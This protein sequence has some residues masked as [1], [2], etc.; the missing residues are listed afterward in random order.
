VDRK[1]A[2]IPQ[3]NRWFIEGSVVHE[4]LEKGFKQAK[5]MSMEYVESIF[6]ETF[7]KVFSEQQVRGVIYFFP[8]ESKEVL[9]AK[10][11]ELL[12]LSINT[13]KKLGMDV[14]EFYSEMPIGTY[15]DPFEFQKGLYIQGSVDWVKDLGTGLIVSDFKTSKDMAYVKAMQLLV[16]AMALEKKLG[17]PV[18]RAFYLMFR[19][20]AQISIPLTEEKKAEALGLLTRANNQIKSGDFK[21]TPL[22]KVCK[23]CVFRN[24]CSFSVVKYGPQEISFGS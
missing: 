24:Q 3:N 1:K 6:D 18:D 7:N 21:A 10:S 23:E 22:E 13:I 15:K 14:G 8:G 20:G 9:R 4:C 11:K 19:S 5:P 16:Y 17:K 12:K 2:T